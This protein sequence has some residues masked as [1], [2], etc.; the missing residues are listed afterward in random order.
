[1]DASVWVT[2]VLILPGVGLLLMSTSIRFGQ[3]LSE[4][5]QL[6]KGRVDAQRFLEATSL[7]SR[8]VH[9]KHALTSLYLSGCALPLASISGLIL[10]EHL[11]PPIAQGFTMLGVVCILYGSGHLVVESLSATRVIK[12]RCANIRR[13]METSAD[14]VTG[15]ALPGDQLSHS[16]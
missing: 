8:T 6:E 1:M 10:G 4:Y 7:G 12:E 11:G 14:N 15:Q 16:E 13:S 9:F 3:L 2:P 5:V